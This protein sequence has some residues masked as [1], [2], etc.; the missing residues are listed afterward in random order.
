MPFASGRQHRQ[1]LPAQYG[2]EHSENAG[3][4]TSSSSANS[5]DNNTH[6][7]KSRQSISSRASS[8]VTSGYL[9]SV[10]RYS[11]AARQDRISVASTANSTPLPSRSASPHLPYL[12]SQPSSSCYSDSDSETD[13]SYLRLSTRRNS[14]WREDR[15]SWWSLSRRKRQRHWKCIRFLKRWTRRILRHPFIPGQPITIVLTL[16]FLSAFAISLTL[17]LIYI[18][19]PDKEPLPWRAYCVA[20]ELVTHS[21]LTNT[22]TSTGSQYPLFNTSHLDDLPPA[23]VFVGVLS[24]DSA[25]ERRMLIRTTWASHP[26]SRNGA[27]GGDDGISTSRT[28]VRFILGQP[29]KDW[30]RRVKLEM[31]TYND[32]V[33]LPVTENMN[34]GKTYTYFSWAAIDAWV[35]PIYNPSSDKPAS[36]FSY[37]NDTSS[38]PQL[39]P[40]DSY[41]AWQDIHYGKARSWVRPD[42]V[43]KVD[44][45]SFVMLAELEARLRYELHSKPISNT[46]AF[47]ATNTSLDAV[48]PS[49]TPSTESPLQQTSASVDMR[50][51][52]EEDPLIYWGYFVMNRSHQFM[53]GELYG[54]SWSL[55]N[56]VATEPAIKSLTKGAEDKQTAKWMRLH[57][58]AM[59]VRWASERCWI[60]DH[61]RSGTV[62]S[63]GFLFPSEVTRIKKHLK[64]YLQGSH[65]TQ[66]LFSSPGSGLSSPPSWAH[67]SVATFGARYAPP[68]PDLSTEHSIEALVEGSDMSMLR[69][70]RPI[71]PDYAWTHREGRR[72]K[73]EGARV[74][75]TVVV[76]FIKKHMWFLETAL[77]LLEGE[78]MSEFEKFRSHEDQR[79]GPE[80]SATSGD[81]TMTSRATLPP[82]HGTQRDTPRRW[83][84]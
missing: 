48:G 35:P 9:S 12:S 34:G 70:G 43:I 41:H 60:Y 23:G 4:D 75:G 40:H 69:E 20:P 66:H 52:Q 16:T 36:R 64:P 50:L 27:G 80:A 76:H 31:D 39:A 18:L 13:A 22:N 21:A 42:Y 68:I 74:G 38:P 47:S 11:T 7:P 62:Y 37:S 28:V 54:L 30:E 61:P 44:D 53:A 56:W 78:E 51:P 29:R 46:K 15:R 45:D 65:E 82:T 58:R 55:V 6:H 24:I 81:S 25:F 14:W 63:H 1:H 2:Q 10:H 19:N 5:D 3:Y 79:Q 57:P 33:I 72:N 59:D 77:A 67:S 17:L 49:A 26:R 71:T 84:L 73:Y 32:I 8:S 83:H